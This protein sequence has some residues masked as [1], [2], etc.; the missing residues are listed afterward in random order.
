MDV[1]A[2]AVE[3]DGTLDIFLQLADYYTK[4]MNSQKAGFFYYKAG[5]YS[6]VLMHF[7][8]RNN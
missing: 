8:L 2:D 1:F 5:Q 7:L 3:D 6:K 4:N